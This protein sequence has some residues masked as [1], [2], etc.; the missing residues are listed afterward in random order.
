M[1]TAETGI[2][3][4]YITRCLVE[5]QLDSL[6]HALALF[7]GDLTRA[8]IFVLVARLSAADWVSG[9]VIAQPRQATPF[10]VNALAASLDRPF[11]TVRRHIMAMVADGICAKSPQGV[12]LA[13]A[14]A[15]EAEVIAFFAGH[16]QILHRLADKIARHD[17]AIARPATPLGDQLRLMVTAALDLGLIA[18]ENN[19]HQS[20]FELIIHGA[21]IHECGIAFIND[22]ALAR[23]YGNVVIPDAMW[24]PVTIRV[25]AE[26]YGMPYATVRRHIDAMQSV[27]MLRKGKGG[28]TLSTEWT[29]QPARIAMSNQTVLYLLRHMRALAASG[30]DLLA[31]PPVGSQ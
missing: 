25:I 20:W 27:G 6:R 10:S 13:P 16:A 14:P 15:R 17:V 24:R 11:E 5:F 9:P 18:L 1:P 31:A 26:K 30:I 23:A 21:M 7:P 8:I 2:P 19:E 3:F 12:I 28:Y 4:R 22:A 29:A